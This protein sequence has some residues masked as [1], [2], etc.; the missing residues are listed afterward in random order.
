[1]VALD[2]HLRAALAPV[3]DAWDPTPLPVA[4]VVCPIV[5]VGGDDHVLLCLRPMHLR[6]H[7]GQVGF[8]GGRREGDETPVQTAL[9]ET[10][11]E[12]GVDA[13][14]IGWLGALPP[15]RSSSGLLVHCLVARL[16]PVPLR[17]D[18][19]EVARVLHAPLAAL[20]D[21]SRW[22][23]EPSQA[24]AAGPQFALD[25]ERLWGLTARF[26]R[27]LVALLP[28]APE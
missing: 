16:Q 2:D 8:P 22:Q 18:P 17:L 28:V 13:T 19:R 14:A 25:G 26:V 27:D 7:A 12:V 6:Q 10:Q 1:V 24:P 21:E 3:P 15:R 5:R 23:T 9:R 11:E 20:A 4:A